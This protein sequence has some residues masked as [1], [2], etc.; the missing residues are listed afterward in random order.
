MD[1]PPL[2]PA[3]FGSP[4]CLLAP[5]VLPETIKAGPATTREFVKSS[6]DGT[7]IGSTTKGAAA[8]PNGV[9]TRSSPLPLVAAAGTAA[10][11]SE[12]DRITNGADAPPIWRFVVVLKL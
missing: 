8:L 3:W 7:G 4:G 11:T 2:L 9:E 12:L 10:T 1:F 6:S 5:A